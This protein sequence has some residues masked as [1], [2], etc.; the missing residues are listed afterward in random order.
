MPKAAGKPDIENILKDPGKHFAAPRDVV[1]APGLGID[2][3]KRIL[4]SWAVDAQLLSVADEENMG[5]DDRPGLREVKLALL[6][7]ERSH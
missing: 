6:E 3:K 4:E 5:G 1:A 7:L 2:E